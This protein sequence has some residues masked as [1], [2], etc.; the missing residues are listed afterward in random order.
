MRQSGQEQQTVL[1][2]DD[3]DVVLDLSRKYLE[4]AGFR[5][6]TALNMSD[7]DRELESETPDLILLDV[8][9]PELAGDDLGISLR[10]ERGIS[11]RIVLFSTLENDEL[12]RRAQA[13]EL[14]G[15]VSKNDGLQAMVATVSHLLR[16]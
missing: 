10:K 2:L 4:D 3:S 15:F 11:A 1:I 8:Q 7:F 5:V 9:M 16:G 12:E 14:D 6:L 13:P